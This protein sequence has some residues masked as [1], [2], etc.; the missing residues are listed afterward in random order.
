MQLTLKAVGKLVDGMVSK[1]DDPFTWFHVEH[2][3]QG[4]PSILGCNLGKTNCHEYWQISS[5]RGTFKTRDEA[6]DVLQKEMDTRQ[7]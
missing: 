6:L 4:K 5:R 3:D 1:P 7:N 2:F